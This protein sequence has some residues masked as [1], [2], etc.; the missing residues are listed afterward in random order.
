MACVRIPKEI[1]CFL[2]C[3]VVVFLLIGLILYKPML[4]SASASDLDSIY[5]IRS[6][7]VIMAEIQNYIIDNPN[8]TV[9]DLRI[10]KGVDDMIIDQL[11]ERFR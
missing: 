9:E 4:K 3:F 6:G 5:G 7:G 8:A 11:K 10:I 2:I 1:K